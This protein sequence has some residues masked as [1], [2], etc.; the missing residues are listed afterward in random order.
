MIIHVY[1]IPVVDVGVAEDGPA[2]SGAEETAG[3]PRPPM[4]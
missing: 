4:D 2:S 3:S 1:I